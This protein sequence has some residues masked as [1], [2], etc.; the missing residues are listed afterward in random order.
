MKY[1]V[2]QCLDRFVCVGAECED[3]CCKGWRIGI[4]RE[5]YEAYRKEKGAFGRRL[6]WGIDHKNRC[7]KLKGR[8]CAFLNSQGFC[9][10]Y[11]EMGREGMCRECR[12]YPRHVEDY[13]NLKEA[14][15]CL[16]CP[17][18]ARVIVRDESQGAGREWER[19]ERRKG[20]EEQGRG[21]EISGRQEES[22]ELLEALEEVRDTLSAL[23]R[24]RPVS[25]GQRLAMALAF[26][27]DFQR[28]W[29]MAWEAG[30]K[31]NSKK[32]GLR[33]VREASGQ[34]SERYLAEEA[35]ERFARRILPFWG[36]EAERMIRMGAWM[37]LT[38]GMEPVLAGWDKI[39]GQMCRELYHEKGIKEYERLRREFEEKAVSLEREWENLAL[40]FVNTYVLG[41]FYDG[42]VYGKAKLAVFSVMMIR[43]RCLFLY[44]R[45][46]KADERA[47][48]KAACR[49]SRQVEN[50]DRNLE[51]LEK[52]LRENRLFSLEGMMAAVI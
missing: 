36:H 48:V 18:A 16:S 2:A 3:T 25:F 14:M 43:E 41:A 24:N 26:C 42:D 40:Y 7:F 29:N 23:L 37:R 6:F 46:G 9:D 32:S 45:E 17:E 30:C 35:A 11:K 1:R 15:L 5:S 51:F 38:E 12:D 31:G 34:L 49:Y 19:G 28:R 13:G 50:S 47:L 8:A 20:R 33:G 10:I 27:H 39:V 22:R 4:D 21:G 52:E 44:G